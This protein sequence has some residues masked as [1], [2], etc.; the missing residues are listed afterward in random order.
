MRKL[1]PIIIIRRGG[2]RATVRRLFGRACLCHSG[3]YLTDAELKLEFLER[4]H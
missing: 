3:S 1:N 2:T 4:G